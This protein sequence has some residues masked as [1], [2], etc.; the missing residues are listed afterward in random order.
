MQLE[1]GGGSRGAAGAPAAWQQQVQQHS[2]Q[3]EGEVAGDGVDGVTSHLLLHGDTAEEDLLQGLLDDDRGAGGA[4]GGGGPEE[5]QAGGT[6]GNNNRQLLLLEHGEAGEVAEAGEVQLEDG[7][8]ADAY[9]DADDGSMG[10]YPEASG[11]SEVVGDADD[12]AGGGASGA[13]R[14]LVASHSLYRLVLKAPALEVHFHVKVYYNY[15]LCP[16]LFTV[17]KMLDASQRGDPVVVS[18]VNGVLKLQQQVRPGGFVAGGRKGMVWSLWSGCICWHM[19][20]LFCFVVRNFDNVSHLLTTRLLFCFP[21]CS[22]RFAAG[23]P[24]G[25]AVRQ[26]HFRVTAACSASASAAQVH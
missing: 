18:D 7:A 22:S 4:A 2:I 9:I 3:E 20:V 5:Q 15:P 13:G 26:R 8:A 6:R 16:P 24:S 21:A 23:K 10:L 17:T 1:A 12:A 19:H 25:S 11:G 14:R